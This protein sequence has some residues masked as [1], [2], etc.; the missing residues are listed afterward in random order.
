MEQTQA[1][2]GEAPLI[3]EE[4]EN[5]IEQCAKCGVSFED[6]EIIFCDIKGIADKTAVE[7]AHFCSKCSGKKIDPNI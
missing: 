5:E 4:C 2:E 6:N 7:K 1:T 3:C